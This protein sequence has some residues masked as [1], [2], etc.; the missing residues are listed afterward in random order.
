MVYMRYIDT[1]SHLNDTRFDDDESDVLL[2]M[3]EASVA[4][5]VVGTDKEMSERAIALAEKH[6]DIW[7]TIG[8]HPTDKHNEVFDNAW[9]KEKVTHKKVVAIGECGLDYY[10]PTN[11]ESYKNFGDIEVEKKRQHELFAEQIA[12]AVECQKPLMIHGRPAQKTMDAYED[13]IGM[14][15]G[16]SVRGNIHFFVGNIEI[17][18]QFL[19]MGFTLSFTGVLTFTHDYDDVVR[20]IPLDML[21]AETDA[22]YVA[23]VPYRGRRNEPAFVVETVAAMARIR[24][25]DET[26]L[27]STLRENAYRVFGCK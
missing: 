11:S 13:I 18:K 9:Y 17:A 26:L 12:L 15:K 22:P 25:V 2:R 1:H 24:G 6:D 20:Y 21:H 27:A 3:R 4:S 7:A 14:L 5:I 23:P 19:D 8:Q 10:W 16:K